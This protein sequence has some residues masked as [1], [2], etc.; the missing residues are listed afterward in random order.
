MI[1]VAPPTGT[2]RRGLYLAVLAFYAIIFVE[3]LLLGSSR[4]T[5]IKASAYL[6]NQYAWTL[7][8]SQSP[9]DRHPQAA[10]PYSLE[11]VRL[12]GERDAH[13]LDTL[14]WSYYCLGDWEKAY[15]YQRVAKFCNPADTRIS[16]HM[17]EIVNARRT[18]P[19]RRNWPLP[20]DTQ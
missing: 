9:R 8:G 14:A 17:L 3:G 4:S 19:L 16:D 20:R 2:L 12:T 6:C 5:R 10:L 13:C 18:A 7:V 1:D 11:A 15:T